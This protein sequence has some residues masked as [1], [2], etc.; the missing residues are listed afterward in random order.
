MKAKGPEDSAL[1]CA[2]AGSADSSKLPSKKKATILSVRRKDLERLNQAD[3]AGAVA[4]LIRLIVAEEMG[5]SLR[6]FMMNL[7]VN[8]RAFAVV[9]LLGSAS[10]NMNG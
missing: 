6:E 10:R 5:W 1:A 7:N 4:R 8:Y 9:I 2:K 3:N